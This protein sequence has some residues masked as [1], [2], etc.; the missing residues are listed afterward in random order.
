[1]RWEIKTALP[2]NSF[3]Y[4][5]GTLITD[6]GFREYDVR[7]LVGKEVNPNGFLLLGKAYGTLIYELALEDTVVVGHDFRA[8]SQELCRSFTVGLLSTGARVIDVGL[9]LTPMVYFGQHRFNAKGGAM[10]T[11]SHNENGWAGIK[12]A[13]GLSSTLGPE[14]IAAYKRIVKEGKYRQGRGTYETCEDLFGSYAEDLLALGRPARP[15]KVVIATGNGTAGCF[16]PKVL[17]RFGCEIVEVDTIGDW[18]FPRHNPNPE[19]LSFLEGISRAVRESG[20]GIGVGID[21][22]GDRIGVVDD[23]GRE[24]FSDKLGLIVAHWLC[25]QAPGRAVVIDVKSTG[26]FFDDPVLRNTGATVLLCKTGHSYIKAAVAESDAVAGFE[27]SGHWFFGRPFGRG[28]DDALLSLSFLLRMLASSGRQLSELVDSLPATYQSPTLS[29]YCADGVKYQVVERMVREYMAAREAGVRI[30]GKL[31]RDLVTV[32]GIRFV[33]EDDS[34][35]LVRASSNKPS[36]VVVAEARGSREQLLAI[37]R[38]LQARLAVTGQVGEY[39]QQ[40]PG[41]EA[42]SH[43]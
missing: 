7:W 30:G 35:G 1:M 27:K 31:I 19:D 22:D 40:M 5:D 4:F 32:N 21:G 2:Y 36:L 14:E 15:L 16:A 18:N 9:C 17:R 3:D 28:Y 26:L 37:I 6:N 33:L 34:W 38:D 24:V 11:A 23:R 20:A 8:Y 10:I 39:D 12:L 43:G 13:K 42:N 25:P 41:L 29:P